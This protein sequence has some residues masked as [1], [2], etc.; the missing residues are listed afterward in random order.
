MDYIYSSLNDKVKL[1]E[2]QGVNSNTTNVIVNND[3]QTIEVKLRDDLTPNEV[4]TYKVPIQRLSEEGELL[5]I[6]EDEFVLMAF[7]KNGNVTKYEY[8]SWR[9]VL[10]R[11]I[12]DTV[13]RLEEETTSLN[14]KVQSLEE[15]SNKLTSDISEEVQRASEAESLLRNQTLSNIELQANPDTYEIKLLGYNVLGDPTV[16]TSIDLPIEDAISGLESKL[17]SDFVKKEDALTLGESS[18]TAYSGDKGKI[19]YD[20]IQSIISGSQLVGDSLKLG[21]KLA[22]EYAMIS[23]L[24][25]TDEELDELVSM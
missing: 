10:G 19:N 20:T 7:V 11:H 22:E 14:Q 24:S 25:I 4:F 1:V 15:T 16:E 8:V 2:Y 3:T 17:E 23:E 13:E 12:I 18:T 21:G 6:Q 9:D 5:P